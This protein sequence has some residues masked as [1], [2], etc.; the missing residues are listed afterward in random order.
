MG[1]EHTVSVGERPKT[2]AL[3]CAA[4]WTGNNNNN[5][6]NNNNLELYLRKLRVRLLSPPH[7]FQNQHPNNTGQ[8]ER[9]FSMPAKIQGDSFRFDIAESEYDNQ[10]AHHL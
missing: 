3:D 1:F 4:T 9:F 10:I 8:K 5:N 7:S 6:N 2:Y